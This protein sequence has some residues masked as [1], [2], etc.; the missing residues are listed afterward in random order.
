MSLV[1]GKRALPPARLGGNALVPPLRAQRAASPVPSHEGARTL[2]EKIEPLELDIRDGAPERVNL[3]VPTIDLEHFFGGYIAKLNLAR[4]L[5]DRGLRVRLVTVDP[6]PPLPRSWRRQ[7]ESYSGLTGLFDRL[8]VA[9]GREQAPLEV[10]NEDR[11]HR[12]HLVDRPHRPRRR[13]KPAR[14]PVPV[15]DPGVRAVHVSDGGLRRA[16]AQEL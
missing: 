5:A 15:H 1:A 14:H 8:E 6:T 12:D 10:S 13:D 2:F 3:L 16:R 11:V 9:F 7:V 4:R